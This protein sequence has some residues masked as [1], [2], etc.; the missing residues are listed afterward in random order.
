M[1]KTCEPIDYDA[2]NPGIRKL[3]R[4]LRET[5]FETVDSG[6][7][8]TRNYECDPGFAY[9][10]IT[11]LP[12]K[13]AQEARRLAKWVR[14]L[15]FELGQW[16]EDGQPEGIVVDASYFPAPD[17]A[18]IQIAGLADKQLAFGDERETPAA[19]AGEVEAP[20]ESDEGL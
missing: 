10:S 5:G 13:L 2:L 12:G 14:G 19:E 4:R 8:A 20:E 9:V 1:P 16:G 15:G 17:E 3:V 11:V 18:I 6:D 7:G